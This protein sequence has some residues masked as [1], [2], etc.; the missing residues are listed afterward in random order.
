MAKVSVIIPVYNVENYL[1]KCLDS[2]VNQTLQD[3]EIICINDGSTD[4]SLQILNEYAQK[5]NRIIVIN[6]ENQG[7]SA[8]RND[9]IEKAGGEFI[10]FLDSDDYFMPEACEIAYNSVSDKY[11]I[12]IFGHYILKGKKLKQKPVDGVPADSINIWD[13][14]FR[15]SFIKENNI[16]FPTQI[17]T[18]EDIIFSY[19]L[20]F[21]NPETI[22]IDELLI[23]YRDARSGSSTENKLKQVQTDVEAFEYFTD[24]EIFKSQSDENKLKV[25]DKFSSIIGWLATKADTKEKQENVKELLQKYCSITEKILTLETLTNIPSYQTCKNPKFKNPNILKTVFSFLKK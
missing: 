16:T 6:K 25:V 3:I 11:D 20:N 4:N 17:T 22:F 9:G 12:G 21:R 15:T 2:V 5:D 10:M 7:V 18:A 1:R 23:V 14:I 8:A 19:E 13:K 24:K